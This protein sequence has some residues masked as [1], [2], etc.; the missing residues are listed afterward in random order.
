[1]TTKRIRWLAAVGVALGLPCLGWAQEV[2]W[3]P[4][5][6]TPETVAAAPAPAQDRPAVT[7][8]KPVPMASPVGAPSA[9]AAR[10]G[11]L[12]WHPSTERSEERSGPSVIVRA[13]A[14]DADSTSSYPPPPPPPPGAVLPVSATAGGF[15]VVAP[16]SPPG[17]G[18]LPSV[19]PGVGIAPPVPPVPE[20]VGM[21]TPHTV[22]GPPDTVAPPPPVPPAAFDTTPGVAL[23]HQVGPSWWEKCKGWVNG[24][25]GSS[26]SR[27][28]FKSDTCFNGLIS[29]VTNPFFFEDPRSLT[30]VRPIFMYQG[31]PGSNMYFHGGDAI[32]FGLQGRL[33]ITDCFSIVMNELGFVSFNPDHAMPPITSDTGFA[34]LK[35]GPKWTFLR[36]ECT[37][38]V[39][40][41]GLTFQI[42]TGDSKVFQNTGLGLDP[43]ITL[44]QTFGRLPNGFG[45][46]NLITE[47]GYSF[48]TD[49]K[50]SDFFHLSAH[51]DYNI[52]N[53]NTFYPLLEFNWL[54]YTSRGKNVVL[55][56]FDEGG[57]LV[58]FGS[59]TRR[60]SDVFTIAPGLRY[61]FSDN[62]F[63]G[64][65]IEFPLSNERGLMDYRVTLDVIFRY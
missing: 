35:I 39:M 36:S 9:P 26:P 60:S 1:M 25:A 18:F 50:R 46:F 62:I 31:V 40:A 52:A 20:S 58:N 5:A 43:Y 54:R 44:G 41:T 65:A 23:D 3:R 15:E 37:G 56:G 64:A 2:V 16:P 22:S 32:F 53:S 33:A 42:P 10:I 51:L 63:A 4:V 59:Y 12:V 24:G 14:I 8:G 21:V 28:W 49:D 11:P 61:R 7:L 30:E 34:E 27:S 38:T 17:S 57:D 13:Q 48:G 6:S 55:P 29:P 47:I 19:S 45:S